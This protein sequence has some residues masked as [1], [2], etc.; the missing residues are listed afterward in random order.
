MAVEVSP[1]R[2]VSVVTRLPLRR[3]FCCGGLGIASAFAISSMLAFEAFE[4]EPEYNMDDPPP[5][6]Q[7]TGVERDFRERTHPLGHP[8]FERKPTGGFAHYAK[9]ISPTLGE[10]G[11]PVFTGGGRKVA[12][13]FRDAQGHPICYL[14]YNPSLGDTAGT[15]GSSVDTGGIQSAD[16][17]SSWFNDDLGNN[18]STSKSLTLNFTLQDD[19]TYVFDDKTDPLYS[20]LG[21]F[22]PIEGELFGNPGGTP[23]RNF[24][25][26]FELHTEFTYDENLGQIFQFIGDDDVWVFIDGKMVID[27]GGV[28]AAREQ[29]VDISR[30]GLEDGETY[31]LA[32][33]YAER[34]RTQSNFRIVTN[35]MLESN[36]TP[37]ISSVFD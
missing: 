3:I 29:Y 7:L 1:F 32:F 33:F 12:S 22:F 34:H 28:H 6:I 15:W 37:T 4:P 25:F 8:D 13:N 24:H 26:T 30:L 20:A 21:G 10:D 18:L 16:T 35:L 17:F 23:N 27:L 11:K 36:D 5:Y 2:R 31:S 14:L 9:N 19:G